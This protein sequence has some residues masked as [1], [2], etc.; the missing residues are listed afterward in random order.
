MKRLLML[1][2]AALASCGEPPAEE[3]PAPEPTIAVPRLLLAA[4]FENLELGAE[5]RRTGGHR[6][7]L[8]VGKR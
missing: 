1:A 7:R 6:S 2:A 4:E 5:D 3:A 8:P